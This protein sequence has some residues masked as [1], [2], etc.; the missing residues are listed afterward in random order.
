M[1]RSETR[2]RWMTSSATDRGAPPS[3]WAHIFSLLPDHGAAQ[4]V[5]Q[6]TNLTL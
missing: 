6:E 4:D 3:L 1:D 5:L 2:Q